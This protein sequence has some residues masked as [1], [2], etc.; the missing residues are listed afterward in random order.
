M[1]WLF[2]STL[3]YLGDFR[4]KL[5]FQQL[6]NC[7]ACNDLAVL[8][9]LYL[10]LVTCAEGTLGSVNCCPLCASWAPSVVN[11]VREMILVKNNTSFSS[12]FWPW[13]SSSFADWS[14]ARSN[15]PC[16][17]IAVCSEASWR[18][19]EVLERG[20]CACL[21]LDHYNKQPDCLWVQVWEELVIE[22]CFVL[23]GYSCFL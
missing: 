8:L 9:Y 7:W 22:M 19:G 10:S 1:Q 13:E 20:C 21:T 23:C 2:F 12:S 17:C 4:E 5:L 11:Q 15:C 18:G 3:F 16:C 14:I 6:L